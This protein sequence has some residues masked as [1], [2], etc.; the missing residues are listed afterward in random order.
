MGS[1]MTTGCGHSSL[2]RQEQCAGHCRHDRASAAL[3]ISDI[4]FGGPIAGIKVGLVDGE[5]V[6]NPT[7]A[8]NEVSILD[9]TVAGTKDAVMMV[10]AGANEVTEE[11][12]LGAIMF[13]HDYIKEL[14]ALQE[15]IR[16]EIGRPKV[17]VPLFEPEP[18]MEQWVREFATERLKLA[19]C[20]PLTSRSGSRLLIP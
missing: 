18:E 14:C 4:P 15:K 6:V 1:A 12:A 20:E 11:Q 2:C 8:Q 17:Q 7:L 9:L 13:A 10:E 19:P 5:Y 16:A 3:H